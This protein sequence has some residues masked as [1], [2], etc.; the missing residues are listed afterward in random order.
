MKIVML[1]LLIVAL[2]AGAALA[3]PGVIGLFSDPQGIDCDL[4][5]TLPGLCTYYVFHHSTPGA[6]A[7]QFSAPLPACMLVTHLSDTAVFPVTIGNSQFGV[8][9]GY[10]TCL[11]APIHILSINVFCQGLTPACCYYSVLPDPAVMSGQIEVVDCSNNLLHG[12]GYRASVNP[13]QSCCCNCTPVEESTWGK[14]KSLYS[15]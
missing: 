9:I 12:M 13:D 8:A 11:T 10:G 6:T 2:G 3:Q 4:F 15:K 14:V 5:D 7:S 1:F